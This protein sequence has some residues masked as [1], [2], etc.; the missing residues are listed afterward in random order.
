MSEHVRHGKEKT[1]VA[2]ATEEVASPPGA[3]PQPTSEGG[4][5]HQQS[6]LLDMLFREA[7][8]IARNLKESGTRR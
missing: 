2:D 6:S 5:K 7:E 4:K 1:V 8:I 3:V